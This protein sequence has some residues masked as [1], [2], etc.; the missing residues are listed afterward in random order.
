MAASFAFVL[1]CIVLGT[2]AV[3]DWR[4]QQ[5]PN[6]LTYPAILAGLAFW[7]AAGYCKGGAPGAW[8]GLVAAAI[9]FAVGFVP[10]AILFFLLGT[11]GG[12]VKLFGAYGA[13]CGHWTCAVDAVIYAY[14]LAILIAVALMI[15][16][17]IVGRTLWRIAHAAILA[18]WRLRPTIPE[19]SPRVTMAV[20]LCAGGLLAG[21]Q[22][23]LGV[24]LPWGG[25]A[26]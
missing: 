18:V 22:H 3:T 2:A 13:L 14:V 7:S 1:L 20:A 12:D 19:D 10:L 5:I 21:A 24:R 8:D 9:A 16:H 15:A 23:L 6:W 17:R 4:T 25:V 11:G 26:G